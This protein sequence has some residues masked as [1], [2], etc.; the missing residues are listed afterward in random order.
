MAVVQR[1]RD[2][3]GW[4]AIFYRCPGC[5]R[6]HGLRL[7]SP[8]VTE[9]TWTW[10]GNADAPTVY[11]AVKVEGCHHMMKD[12][13]LVFLSTSTHHLACKTVEMEEV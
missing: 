10:N 7:R 9:P 1:I 12:G 8:G 2:T 11:P 6:R 5:G 3:H 4:P 13:K